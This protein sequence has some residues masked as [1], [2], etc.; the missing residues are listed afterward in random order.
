MEQEER[1]ILTLDEGTSSAKAFIFD[2]T[3]KTISSGQHMFPQYYSQPGWVEHNPMEI[4]TAQRKAIK[5]AMGQANIQVE[6][7]ES[8]GIT[9][10]RETTVIW[11]KKT[12]K[13]IHN[14]IVWQDRRTSDIIDSLD[15]TIKQLIKTKSGL[16][17]DAYFSASKIQWMLDHDPDA[18][19][20]AENGELLFGTIDTFLLYHLTDGKVHATDHSNASRTMLYDINKLRWDDELLEIFKIPENI[21]PT[22]EDSSTIY[23][24][25]SEK[26]FGKKITISGCA[27]DQQAALFGQRCFKKGMV[28][29]T[30]GT[31]N[32]LLMNTGSKPVGSTN[33]LTTV[34]WVIDGQPTYSLEGSIFVTGAAVQ[35][36]KDIGIIND[37]DSISSIA[38]SEPDNQ[39][40]YFIPAFVGLGAPYWD[41]YAR[42]TIIGITRGT[43]KEILVRAALESI[44]YSSQDIIEE[45]Q[46]D[47]GIPIT[48]VHVDGG[49]TTNDFLLQHHADISRKSIIK[50]YQEHTTALGA[51]FL[52]GLSTN[53]WENID[54]IT[55]LDIPSITFEPLMPQRTSNILYEGWKKAVSHSKEWARELDHLRLLDQTQ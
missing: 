55:Q 47:S 44:C 5:E 14:A 36:L 19:K 30:F 40:V 24:S 45:M 23:G 22:I 1:Y 38:M 10:Q 37:I 26:T 11:K 52:A 17:P 33:I 9:N 12:G 43:T 2:K 7:L 29:N 48:H 4:W 34:A 35:W 46:N 21:L 28:K 41:Q 39:G 25:T 16:I 8:I 20:Q 27:G 18:R 42:G 32:F 15:P 49:G 13:P 6:E 50:P 53:Y 31:G 51:A 54:E 3:G